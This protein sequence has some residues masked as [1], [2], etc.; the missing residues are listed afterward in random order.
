MGLRDGAGGVI[1]GPREGQA[2]RGGHDPDWGRCVRP[3]EPSAHSNH[4]ATDARSKEGR[5]RI[6]AGDT[7]FCPAAG[8]VQQQPPWNPFDGLPGNLQATFQRAPMHALLVSRSYITYEEAMSSLPH[9]MAAVAQAFSRWIESWMGQ[10]YPAFRERSRM[11][12]AQS[13]TTV[14]G[15]MVRGPNGKSEPWL[16]VFADHPA[17]GN[18]MGWPREVLPVLQQPL[19]NLPILAVASMLDV[20]AMWLYDRQVRR[21]I[22]AATGQRSVAILVGSKQLARIQGGNARGH[23]TEALFSLSEGD[24]NVVAD[25]RHTIDA[26]GLKA[27]VEARSGGQG[28]VLASARGPGLARADVIGEIVQA[29]GWELLANGARSLKVVQW[30]R[31]LE[32]LPMMSNGRPVLGLASTWEEA[33]RGLLNCA[34]A[35]VLAGALLRHQEA[36]CDVWQDP[37]SQCCGG[38]CVRSRSV[39]PL[40][41]CGC[42]ETAPVWVH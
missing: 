14:R 31:L 40:W 13:W 28:M 18:I 8:R 4:A 15:T 24:D 29:Y 22:P 12:P 21:V 42:G 26:L 37:W 2:L 6:P 25:D 33:R 16:Q 39:L 35:R 32:S 5:V 20:G 17:V 34:T 3:E 10:D 1:P 11:V 7:P 30:P 23:I 9:W 19:C 38:G 36:C 41:C 27:V